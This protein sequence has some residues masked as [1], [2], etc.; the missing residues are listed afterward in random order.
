MDPV[1]AAEVADRNRDVH[2]RHQ[3]ARRAACLGRPG[4]RPAQTS[5][6]R[7]PKRPGLP[8]WR[9]SMSPPRR[10]RQRARVTCRRAFR[11]FPNATPRRHGARPTRWRHGFSITFDRHHA[12]WLGGHANLL[13]ALL[14]VMLAHD[15]KARF[16]VSVDMLFLGL[17]RPA[18]AF[19]GQPAPCWPTA[20]IPPEA[21]FIADDPRL[22]ASTGPERLEGRRSYHL[23]LCRG[24]SRK[25]WRRPRRGRRPRNG[26]R[27][28]AKTPRSRHA[29]K[30]GTRRTTAIAAAIDECGFDPTWRRSGAAPGR[31][32]S[33]ITSRGVVLERQADPHPWRISPP[34]MP[35]ARA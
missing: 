3:G 34:D 4:C 13:C 35:Y 11:H 29:V 21:D 27:C 31:L 8:L 14:E 19:N 5:R 20:G 26:P 25:W 22:L 15:G 23:E 24:M 16:D 10:G 28:P 18:F 17:G 32:G 33:G 7:W 12:A 30:P 2:R 9:T 1:T 6:C